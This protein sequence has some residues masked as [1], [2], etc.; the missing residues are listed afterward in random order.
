M[1]LKVSQIQ[2]ARLGQRPPTVASSQVLRLATS[3]GMTEALKVLQ[4]TGALFAFVAVGE[5]LVG[6]A[7]RGQIT[8]E[9]SRESVEAQRKE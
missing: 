6:R 1:T 2:I 3:A 8:K 5:L 7:L 9:P 4:M